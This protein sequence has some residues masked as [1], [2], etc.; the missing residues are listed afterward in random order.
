MKVEKGEGESARDFTSSLATEKP[1]LV[2]VVWKFQRRM[3]H[4][5]LCLEVTILAI[6]PN[7]K[8]K[9]KKQLT[10]SLSG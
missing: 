4:W 10:Y 8:E 3:D 7:Q 5:S 6:E 1:P 9:G 2:G